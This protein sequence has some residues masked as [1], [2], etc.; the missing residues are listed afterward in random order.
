MDVRGSRWARLVVSCAALLI[1]LA[2]AATAFAQGQNSATLT[3]TVVDNVGVVPG[4]T[5][6]VTNTAT[7]ATGTLRKKIDCQETFST[8]K[9]LRTSRARSAC[10]P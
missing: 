3:G 4:A 6:T 7:I 10:P 2:G 8:R 5:V 1:C 9:P